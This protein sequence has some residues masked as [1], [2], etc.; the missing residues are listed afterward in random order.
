MVRV[1]KMPYEES[2]DEADH[3][4]A[5]TAIEQYRDHGPDRSANLDPLVAHLLQRL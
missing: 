2:Y 1:L 3:R 5:F 4:E